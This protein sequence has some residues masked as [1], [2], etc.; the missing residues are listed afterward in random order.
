MR[1]EIRDLYD[2]MPE[3]FLASFGKKQYESPVLGLKDKLTLFSREDLELESEEAKDFYFNLLRL[4]KKLDE[5]EMRFYV[6]DV[7]FMM[8]LVDLMDSYDKLSSEAQS[9]IV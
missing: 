3:F 9:A 8:N 7:E 4:I 2:Y 5:I 1:K 6:Y